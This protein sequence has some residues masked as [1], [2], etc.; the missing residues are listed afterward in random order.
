MQSSINLSENLHTARTLLR[1][2]DVNLP[3]A[4]GDFHRRQPHRGVAGVAAGGEVEF[5]AVPGADDVALFAEAQP[6]ALL[7]RRDDFLDLM[8]DLALA[9]RA[10]RMGTDVFVGQHLAAGAE[11]ADFE[12]F[13][14]KD[15]VVAIG[16][17]SEL[18]Y[19]DFV[20]LLPLAYSIP[21][22]R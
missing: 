6:R 3:V 8:E 9:H 4:H 19:C 17:V 5:V 2:A 10:A 7:V 12:L 22:G 20:H 1:H 13:H 18:A 21:G 11:D 14:G 16:D 15:A